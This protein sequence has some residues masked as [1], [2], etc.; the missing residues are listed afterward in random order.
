MLKKD[1]DKVTREDG[2]GV[3]MKKIYYMTRIYDRKI[4]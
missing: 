1:K 3:F 4:K 2:I